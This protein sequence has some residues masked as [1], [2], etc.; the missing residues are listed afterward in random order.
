MLSAPTRTGRH[1]LCT[2]HMK[3]EVI[4]GTVGVGTCTD[5]ISYRNWEEIVVSTGKKTERGDRRNQLGPALHS[6]LPTLGHAWGRAQLQSLHLPLVSFPGDL[7]LPNLFLF[8][9]KVP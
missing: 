5:S 1:R 9:K 4:P 6:L 3:L 8:S 7:Q 2:V